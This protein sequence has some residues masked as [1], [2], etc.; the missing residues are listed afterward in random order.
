MGYLA[1]GRFHLRADLV[2]GRLPLSFASA[3]ESVASVHRLRRA[4][5]PGAPVG[6]VPEVPQKIASLRLRPRAEALFVLFIW[7]NP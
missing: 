1:A 4:S 3:A 7:N 6:A 5:D 2:A